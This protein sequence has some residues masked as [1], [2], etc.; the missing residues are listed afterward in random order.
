LPLATSSVVTGTTLL[1]DEGNTTQPER[2]R[3]SKKTRAA[4]PG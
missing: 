4:L 2:Y 1:V 3:L